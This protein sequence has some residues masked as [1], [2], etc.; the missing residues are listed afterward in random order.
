[1][2]TSVSSS[3]VP[4]PVRPVTTGTPP[5]GFSLLLP[6]RSVNN[7]RVLHRLRHSFLPSH[8]Q[9][10]V[11][12]SRRISGG[13]TRRAPDLARRDNRGAPVKGFLQRDGRRVLDRQR[14][15][16]LELGEHG[17]GSSQEPLRYHRPSADDRSVLGERTEAGQRDREDRSEK[18]RLQISVQTR[19][20]SE[21]RDRTREKRRSVVALCCTRA[22]FTG[23]GRFEFDDRARANGGVGGFER[24]R[25]KHD[26]RHAVAFLRSG[27]GTGE[28]H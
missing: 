24:R 28:S 3:Y 4:G 8:P 21:C 17:R 19:D 10:V 26:C 11:N 27:R 6:N 20:E 15:T 7:G 5:T 22:R 25:E 23:T 13:V 18:R 9:T 1:M 14:A 12:R 2:S 16:V